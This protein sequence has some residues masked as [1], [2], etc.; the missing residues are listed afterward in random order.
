MCSSGRKQVRT[1]D[2]DASAGTNLEI[3]WATP[4]TTT[5]FVGPGSEFPGIV[6]V[7]PGTSSSAA[8]CLSLAFGGQPDRGRLPRTRCRA[9][10]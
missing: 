10:R 1:R 4:S 9:Y 7:P 8:D 3:E 6:E 5:E 2:D